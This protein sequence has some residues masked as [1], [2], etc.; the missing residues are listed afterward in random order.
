MEE[1]YPCWMRRFDL[2]WNVSF[3][4]SKIYIDSTDFSVLVFYTIMNVPALYDV[5]GQRMENLIYFIETGQKLREGGAEDLRETMIEIGWHAWPESPLLGHGFDSFKY[6]NVQVTGRFFY[7]HNNFI[8]LLY[9]LGIIGFIV[10]YWFYIKMIITGWDE[11]NYKPQYATYFAIALFISM[12]FYET[13]AINYS[14]TTSFIIFYL[15]FALLN[16]RY[17]K[18]SNCEGVVI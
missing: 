17:Q 12:L 6:Y 16:K 3:R 7:S 13:G 2:L 10:Y 1:N 8:E 14:A 4:R 5:I 18:S 11:R 15:S 9:N